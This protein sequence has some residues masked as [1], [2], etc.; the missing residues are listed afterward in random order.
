MPSVRRVIRLPFMT[1]AFGSQRSAY[2][3][4]ELTWQRSPQ[5]VHAVKLIGFHLRCFAGY[6]MIDLSVR[7]AIVIGAGGALGREHALQLVRT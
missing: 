7:V 1:L 4:A 2:E 6:Q 5:L 3:L